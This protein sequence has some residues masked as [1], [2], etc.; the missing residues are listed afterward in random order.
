MGEEGRVWE[1]RAKY[2]RRGWG[3][4]GEGKVWE[5]RVGCGR[6]GWG[7]CGEEGR[8]KRGQSVGE[9]GVWEERRKRMRKIPGPWFYMY[10]ICSN[11]E[12]LV[13]LV[14]LAS[15]ADTIEIKT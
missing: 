9:G 6:R 8:C 5:E 10:L 15:S 13:F 12:Q 4:G 1:E 2:G 11:G 3:V 7:V 14:Q